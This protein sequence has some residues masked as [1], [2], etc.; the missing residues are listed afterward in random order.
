[1]RRR[2][3]E[4]IPDSYLLVI[5]QTDAVKW[6]ETG[7][8]LMLDDE[9]YDVIK[10]KTDK[11]KTYLYCLNDDQETQV[12][13]KFSKAV[14]SRNNSSSSG[15]VAKQLLKFQ[16]KTP[17]SIFTRLTS[18]IDLASIQIFRGPESRI[19]SAYKEVVVPPPRA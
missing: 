6:V 5:E 19:L 8:E 16:G 15:K 11:D 9:L 14:K 13:K 7:K 12:L 3:L 10:T 18:R 4:G 17:P 2:I 1:M